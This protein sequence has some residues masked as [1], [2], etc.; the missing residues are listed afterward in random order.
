MIEP[1]FSVG[2]ILANPD[3]REALRDQPV[4]LWAIAQTLRAEGLIEPETAEMLQKIALDFK[5][6][7]AVVEDAAKPISNE[8]D[9]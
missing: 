6:A 3:I 2:E 7:M 4:K 8:Q 5:A 9:L 1:R